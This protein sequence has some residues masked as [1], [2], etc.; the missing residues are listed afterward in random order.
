MHLRPITIGRDFGA[1]LEIVGGID[2]SDRIVINP[3]DSIEEGQQVHVA[4]SN[5]GDARS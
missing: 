3:S 1:T 4:K 5:Q 2:A